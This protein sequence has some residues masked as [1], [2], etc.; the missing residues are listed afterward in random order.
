MTLLQSTVRFLFGFIVL[1]LLCAPASAT[2]VNFSGT[3]TWTQIADSTTVS[4]TAA[5]KFAFVF[6]AGPDLRITRI[7][8]ELGN[9]D[10]ANNQTRTLFWDV[11][12]AAP[13]FRAYGSYG[14]SGTSGSISTI[15]G[16]ADG[17]DLASH[18]GAVTFAS[19]VV[20]VTFLLIGDVDRINQGNTCNNDSNNGTSAIPPSAEFIAGGALTFR[21]YLAST[22]PKLVHQRCQQLSVWAVGLGRRHLRW[23][24]RRVILLERPGR[25]GYARARHVFPRWRW[26]AHVG[27]LGPQEANPLRPGGQNPAFHHSGWH[28]RTTRVVDSD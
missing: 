22:N 11:S 4:D 16:I 5:S 27:L 26:A 6:S 20:G 3:V 17:T 23:A 14:T 2:I 18:Y 24:T 10:T 25:S 21:I 9:G 28:L 12:S 1:G 7:D 8:F 15:D 19:F 13:G